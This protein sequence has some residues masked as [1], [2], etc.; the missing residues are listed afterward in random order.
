MIIYC[1][2][3]VVKGNDWKRVETNG[4]FEGKFSALSIFSSA[5][6]I[7]CCFKDKFAFTLFN[8]AL[9][10][11]HSLTCTQHLCKTTAKCVDTSFCP[12]K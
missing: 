1:N 10:C 2:R 12:L 7:A 3:F 11:F 8:T 4:Q 5:A 9:N 6:T